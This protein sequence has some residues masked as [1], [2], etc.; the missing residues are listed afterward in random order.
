MTEDRK[1]ELVD[2]VI[3]ELKRDLSQGDETILDELLKMIPARNLVQ[4]LPEEK[5]KNYPEIKIK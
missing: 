3:E 1:Q 2:E 5:W 4:A